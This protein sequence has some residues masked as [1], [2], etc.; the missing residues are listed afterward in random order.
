MRNTLIVVIICCISMLSSCTEPSPNVDTEGKDE[1]QALEVEQSTE[2]PTQ[3]YQDVVYVPIYSDIYANETD[4]KVLLSAT[5]SVRNTSEV[6]SL[7]ISRID[8]FDTG[9]NIVR[10]YVGNLISL[11][12]MATINYVIE[13][14]DDT[15]GP[16]ANFIV[17]LSAEHENVRPLIQAVMVSHVGNKSFAFSTDGY[18]VK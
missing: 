10:S 16:G 14:D 13:K 11:P 8:Y 5:L 3:N 2:R 17:E 7:F 12:P 6:D 15:G 4:Q 18:S 1:F 9:G